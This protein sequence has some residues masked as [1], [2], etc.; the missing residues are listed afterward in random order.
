[1]C[2]TL[3]HIKDG[4]GAKLTARMLL[5]FFSC[6]AFFCSKQ[7]L[8]FRRIGRARR[9]LTAA[10]DNDGDDEHNDH[11]DDDID[12]DAEDDDDDDDDDGG[13][14]DADETPMS[15]DYSF[16]MGTYVGCDASPC[17]ASLLEWYFFQNFF[18]LVFD[19]LPISCNHVTVQTCCH[20]NLF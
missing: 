20:P 15:E 8:I 13:D 5:M 16:L 12:N 9:A 11:D 2:L 6:V 4:P 18:R 14:D 19:R 1:M 17:F 7:V 10:D 3:R